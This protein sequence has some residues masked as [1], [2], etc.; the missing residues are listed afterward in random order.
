MIIVASLCGD[1]DPLSK[2]LATRRRELGLSQLQLAAA[3]GDRYNR[4]MI[5]HV[6]HGRS[7]LLF[8]GVIQAAR[9]LGVS[10]DWL[11][12]LTDDPRPASE[13]AAR[14][15]ALERRQAGGQQQ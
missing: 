14:V 7:A 5:S 6:E 2:R 10:V 13:L 11:A 3:M 8:E 15:A 1:L 9:V 12:G 4:Q